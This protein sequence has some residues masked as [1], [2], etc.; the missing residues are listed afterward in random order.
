MSGGFKCG[1][2]AR[3]QFALRPD[4]EFDIDV[5]AVDADGGLE[6]DGHG[7]GKIGGVAAAAN[8]ERG[9]SLHIRQCR[10]RRRAGFATRLALFTLT[11]SAGPPT[12]LRHP[13]ERP[14]GASR[15]SRL[16]PLNRCNN[17]IFVE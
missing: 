13:E 7:K 4:A 15:Q 6:G 5:A 16:H 12:N 1:D 2:E 9:G 17:L 3:E 11:N 10:R 8:G 14:K